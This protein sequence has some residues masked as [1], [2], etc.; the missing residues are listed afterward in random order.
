MAVMHSN[1]PKMI[2]SADFY[3]THHSVSDA[4]FIFGVQRCVK[5]KQTSCLSTYNHRVNED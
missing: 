4:F 3:R 2:R 1:D 5:N